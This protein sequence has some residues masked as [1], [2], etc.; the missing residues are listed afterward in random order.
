MN[1]PGPTS[2][3]EAELNT[4]LVPEVALV[5]VAMREVIAKAGQEIVKLCRPYGEVFAQ[6]NVDASADDKIKRIVAGRRAEIRAARAELVNISVEIAVSSTE[7]GLNKWLNMRSAEFY[8]R[9]NVVGKQ[10]A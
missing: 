10:V 8:D 6:R 4:G 3:L 1:Y 5:V 9:T 2:R 7:Q